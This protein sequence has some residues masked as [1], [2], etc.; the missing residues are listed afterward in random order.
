[1]FAVDAPE[2]APAARHGL[3]ETANVIEASGYILY[4]EGKYQPL[5]GGT[6]RRVPAEGTDKTFD[7]IPDEKELILFSQYRGV[8]LQ[9]LTQQGEGVPMLEKVFEAG[10]AFAVEA[11]IQERLLSPAAVDIT[12]TPG[13]PVTNMRQAIGLLEQ[14]AGERWG[15]RPLI[16]GNLLAVSL[17][18]DA[19]P[20]DDGT[21]STLLGTPIA[22]AVGYGADG[23]GTATADAGEAW[24]Y[25]TGQINIWRGK[26]EFA[27]GPNPAEN[28]E[29]T[30]AEKSYAASVDGP[31]AAILVSGN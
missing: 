30:L 16:S 7:E 3:L 21:L 2:L 12:P 29:L 6:N 18:R 4:K 25:I 10:E 11:E 13:T 15:Y 22:A 31:V 9:L 8:D 1:M 5:L 17:I 24:L 19:Q 23:P 26:A 20:A 14:Y 28:K 27:V